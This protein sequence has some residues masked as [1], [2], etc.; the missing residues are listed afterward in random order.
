MPAFDA[1]AT[2]SGSA[3]L[4]WTHTPVG[5]PRGIIVQTVTN[6]VTDN[7]ITGVTYGGVAMSEVLGSPNVHATGEPAV[8]NTFFLGSNI[9]VGPQ[10]VTVLFSGVDAKRG[11][12]ISLTG[13]A[14]IEVIDIGN[15]INGDS[16]ANPSEILTLDGRSCFCSI[17]FQSGQG[18][19]TLITPLPDWT[20]R[21][22][23][24]MGAQVVGFYTYDIIGTIDVTSG[25]IQTAEDAVAISIA[26]SEISVGTPFFTTIDGKLI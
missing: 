5:T 1:F 21:F 2:G 11:I 16:V 15:S 18:A 19:V 14:D 7:V 20:E 23:S 26:V 6:N 25:W 10:T 13:T 9:P 24:D 17:G 12:S 8:V 4:S 3:S 22:E